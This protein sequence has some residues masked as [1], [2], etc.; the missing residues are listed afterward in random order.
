[1]MLSAVT[2]MHFKPQERNEPFG[3]KIMWADGRRSAILSDFRSHVG[4]LADMAEH[5]INPVLRARLADVSWLLERK[6]GSLAIAAIAA[7]VDIVQKINRNE[8]NYRFAEE[9][10]V[11]QHL[12]RD[13]LLRALQVGRAAGWD[14]PE[15]IAARELTIELR[16]QAVAKRALNPTL[17]F[18]E[19]DVKFAISDP[20]KIGVDLDELLEN[21][22]GDVH[23]IVN[24][25]QTAARAY[26]LAKMPD[27]KDRCLAEAAERLAVEADA[28]QNSA[29]ISA[30][31]LSSAIAQLHGITGKKDRRTELRHKLVDLQA[32][33]PEEMSV[34]SQELDLKEIVEKVQE[35]VS[36]GSLLD[37][38][39]MFASLASSPDP[40]K[41][42]SD[43]KDI[44]KR[45]PFSSL[46]GMAHL[47]HEG[48][49][50][51]RSQSSNF[52]DAGDSAIRNKIAQA[53]SLR[54]K[55][56]ASGKIDV[57]RHI[58]CSHHFISDDILVRLLRYSPLIPPNLVA[59]F[60]HGFARF[61]QGDFASAVYILTP[62]LENSLRHFLKFNGYDVTIFNDATQ[63]QEDRTISSLFEQMRG[64]LD[65]ILTPAIAADIEHVF[66][67]KPGPHLRHAVAHGLLQDS[68]PYGADA[69]YGCWL[70]FRLCI[71]PLVPYRK[72]LQPEMIIDEV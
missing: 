43:A 72:E 58:I 1:M 25:W 63:T 24:L 50:I 4:L 32:R 8:L 27:D 3:P 35:A 15:T 17:W 64:E 69:I 34:L 18:C 40:E 51:Y 39:F 12:A 36:Q 42:I 53:E 26:H 71:L 20:V 21:L 16:K 48:K 6:R 57:A 37:R 60:A 30:H 28:K 33:I 47:D 31:F 49:V 65:S 70:I 66:L 5:A 9:D 45:Y 55:M 13:Y 62:L 23:L 68:D 14:K 52:D 22:E 67:C 59:T 54:R 56:I 11:L 2:G 19:L 61:F 38:L 41:L 44:I 7:Y 29:M 46:F 10:G